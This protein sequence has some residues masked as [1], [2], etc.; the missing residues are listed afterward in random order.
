MEIFKLT[1]IALCLLIASCGKKEE[2]EVA[3]DNSKEVFSVWVSDLT[4]D[5]YDMTAGAFSFDFQVLFGSGVCSDG[6]GDFTMLITEIGDIRFNNCA[7]AATLETASW[8][9]TCNVLTLQY[10]SDSSIETFRGE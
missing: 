9:K 7:D 5:R 1:L 4:G 3:C 10:D 2:L 6:R 8:V